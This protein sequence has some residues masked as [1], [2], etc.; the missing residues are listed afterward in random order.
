MPVGSG[1]LYTHGNQTHQ[2][3]VPGTGGI[4]KSD[5]VVNVLDAGTLQS[6]Q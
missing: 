6:L 2:P 5:A 1:K 4:Y 3:P